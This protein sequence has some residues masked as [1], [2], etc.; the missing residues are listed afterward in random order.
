MIHVGIIGMGIRG[1]LYADTIQF[2]PYA[3]LTAL[4]EKEERRLKEGSLDYDVKVPV[5]YWEDLEDR[6]IESLCEKT[7]TRSHP[8]SGLILLFLKESLLID[9]QNRCL[10]HQ[11][12]DNWEK[13]DNPLL[14]LV[15]LA[16][17]LNAGPES[18][19]HEMVSVKELK[20]AHFF[21]G[22]HEL[23]IRPLLR[24]Y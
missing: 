10:R 6:E 20:T 22:P 5:Q 23:N 19:D 7:L 18:L 3:E 16:Y 15:C 17:L 21:Q 13:I 8:P 9:I 1:N 11:I 4:S 2:N 24:R 12:Q 14:E